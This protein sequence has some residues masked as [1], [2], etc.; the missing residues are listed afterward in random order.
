MKKIRTEKKNSTTTQ[1]ISFR[2][3]KLD[4]AK[5]NKQVSKAKVSRSRYIKHA[6]W[7]MEAIR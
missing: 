1:M 2:M 3:K 5:L 4:V 7:A 6:I